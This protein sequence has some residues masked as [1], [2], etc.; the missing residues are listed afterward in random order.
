LSCQNVGTTIFSIM[1]VHRTPL[2]M[3]NDFKCCIGRQ[4]GTVQNTHEDH[5]YLQP[6]W[7]GFW[8]ILAQ[9]TKHATAKQKAITASN[10]YRFGYMWFPKILY[11][12][13]EF[14]PMQSLG[15]AAVHG[16]CR[17]SLDRLDA[18][19]HAF[20]HQSILESAS[21]ERFAP[22]VWQNVESEQIISPQVQRTGSM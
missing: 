21:S 1:P 6:L 4:K 10:K 22:H 2:Q 5:A 9:E 20:V 15:N 18:K 3:H 13:N 8:P 14:V 7:L 16:I 12:H 17:L 11:K 19:L